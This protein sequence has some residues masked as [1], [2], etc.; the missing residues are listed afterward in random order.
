MLD[1]C[2]W[3]FV[4]RLAEGHTLVKM[5][6]YENLA[7]AE[8]STTLEKVKMKAILAFTT[9]CKLYRRVLAAANKEQNAKNIIVINN[10]HHKLHVCTLIQYPPPP[11]KNNQQEKKLFTKYKITKE[12][13]RKSIL[14]ETQVTGD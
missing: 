4:T 11:N 14:S 3:G 8:I 6:T 1:L 10:S 9:C 13:Y 5:A 7:V 12:K 2:K